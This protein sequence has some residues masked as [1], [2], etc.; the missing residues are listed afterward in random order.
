MHSEDSQMFLEKKLKVDIQSAKN[1]L[2]FID[3]AQSSYY[4]DNLNTMKTNYYD[5]VE[6]R[7]RSGRRHA[8]AETEMTSETE[9]G[10]PDRR[11]YRQYSTR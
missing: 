10:N 8:A 1:T 4:D 9:R 2:V 3:D 7:S 11:G 6:A 5:G